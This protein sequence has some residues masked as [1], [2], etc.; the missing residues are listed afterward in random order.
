MLIVLVELGQKLNQMATLTAREARSGMKLEEEI[1]MGEE[2]AESA[3]IS[4]SFVPPPKWHSSSWRTVLKW[5]ICGH[6]AL[7]HC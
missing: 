2:L 7:W 1:D 6:G 3:V 4:K 5:L